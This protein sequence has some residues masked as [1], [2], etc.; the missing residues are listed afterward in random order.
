[1]PYVMFEGEQLFGG[2][3]GEV[4]REFNF[5]MSTFDCA[6]PERMAKVLLHPLP[7]EEQMRL[8]QIVILAVGSGEFSELPP[9]LRA[10]LKA[11]VET[12]RHVRYDVSFGVAQ[13][14]PQGPRRTKSKARK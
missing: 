4:K 5:I 2:E 9:W 10:R 11:P 7:L 6:N 8:K 12:D 3:N 13:L 1:M 14:T